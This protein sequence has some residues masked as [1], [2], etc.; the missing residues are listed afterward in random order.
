MKSLITLTLMVVSTVSWSSDALKG[1]A[2]E[3]ALTQ[4]ENKQ[5]A[6]AH[7]SSIK[8]TQEDPK[9]WKAWYLRGVVAERLE[10]FEDADK[11]YDEFFKL[12]PPEKAAQ[13]IKP[14]SYRSKGKAEL[15][16]VKRYNA[17]NT[18]F[19]LGYS[20]SWKPK[21]AEELGSNL[22]TSWDLGFEFAGF[23]VGGKGGSGTV[24]GLLVAPRGEVK[25]KTTTPTYSAL[26]T[27]GKHTFY[28]FFFGYN[29]DLNNPY[30]KLGPI[31]LSIPLYLSGVMN[32][33]EIAGR[34]FGSIGYDGGLG[35][36]ARYYTKS[37]F[38]AD[39]AG[40][41]HSGFPFWGLREDGTSSPVKSLQ[42]AESK[43][44]MTGFEIRVGIAFLF[45]QTVN[46][47]EEF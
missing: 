35:L 8:A 12:S 3:Q 29:F 41:Y 38:A 13:A 22:S 23:F 39:V 25:T 5:W 1:V 30:E 33:I 21:L 14:R 9:S 11:S 27:E 4:T 47:P 26:R 32:T 19:F 36:R 24:P 17:D 44:G 18:K 2:Y 31:V 42:G 28:E 40:M 37:W 10:N 46:L 6:Q 45:A 20:P 7:E 16:T 15:I 43:S 34:K